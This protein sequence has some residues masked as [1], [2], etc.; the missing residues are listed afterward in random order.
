MKKYFKITTFL[1]LFATLCLSACGGG[2]GGGGGGGSG[3]A[4]F[5]SPTTSWNNSI[6]SAQ[7]DA[8]KTTEYNNQYGLGK[9]NAA[10]AYALLASNSKPV[11]GDGV[12]IVIEDT[13]V[14]ANHVDIAANLDTVNSHN[15]F[16]NSS[17]YSDVVGHGTHVAAIAAGV[18]NGS[19]MHGVA[20]N[21]QIV[22]AE[23]FNNTAT[24]ISVSGIGDPSSIS[25][26]KVINASYGY[27]SFST[28]NGTGGGE[29]SSDAS[30]LAQINNIK[31]HDILYVVATGND[32]D[33]ANNG[34]IT[35]QD[36]DYLTNPKPGKPALF[37]N[38]ASLSGFVLAVGAVDAGA[39]DSTP[40]IADFSNICG[41]TKDYCLV[42]PGIAIYSAVSDTNT[43]G[44]AGY[45]VTGSNGAKYGNING[46][47]M[48]APQVTGAVAVIRAAWPHLTAPQTAQIL[49]TTATDKGTPGVDDIYGHGE[50]NLYAAVQAQGQNILAYGTSVSLGGY[51]DARDASI[52][53]DPIFGD[54]LSVN[55]ASALNDAVFFDDYGRDYKANLGS[56][57]ATRTGGASALS[58][59]N[60]MLNRY[61]TNLIP[62]SFNSGNFENLSQ[63]KFQIKSYSNNYREF[64][65]IDKSKQDENLTNGN[66]FSFAQNFDK[67]MRL[68]FSFNIDENKNNNFQE[69]NNFSFLTANNFSANPYQAFVNAGVNDVSNQRNFNQIILENKISDKLKLNFSYQTSYSGN[70]FALQNVKKE[71]QISDFNFGYKVNDGLKIGLS[72]GVVDE[73]N[74]N[75]LNSKAVGAFETSGNTKTS[76]AK[77]SLKQKLFDEVSLI[78]NFS[79]GFTKAKGNEYGIFRKFSNIYSRSQSIGLIDENF[80]GSKFGVIY[81]EPLRVYKGRADIDVAIARDIDGN[82]TRYQ[83]NVSLKS[84]GKERNL[85][86]FYA[87]D[88]TQS[89]KISFNFLTTKDAGNIKSK[90]NSYLGFVNYGLYF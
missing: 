76:Y 9:I 73:F 82:I 17:D 58:L 75:F 54:A 44:A 70:N 6:T 84:Q 59:S 43:F 67:K 28:Y 39:N 71:N 42:T 74:N 13:G 40:N 38:N 77:I 68:A 53:S 30:V 4:S 90:N 12:K 35:G 25:G 27:G 83:D 88:L 51:Y 86:I 7:A 33:N 89:S 29:D 69:L 8:Y 14:Q 18:K 87:H 60:I 36:P 41:V 21:A 47:S 63:I 85:E 11:G 1:I 81:N 37:A 64:L 62:L 16:L 26:V 24:S 50:L 32:A 19:G 48:A 15:Y 49:L 23:I 72:I 34:Q 80:F 20:F 65:N 56:K 78:A 5:S 31:S 52:I 57:I 22:A 45:T 2:G 55:V 79:Q 3:T 10:E 46:T 66:G 61:K